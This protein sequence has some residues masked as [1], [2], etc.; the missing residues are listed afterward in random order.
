MWL[1]TTNLTLVLQFPEVSMVTIILTTSGCHK[2]E[3]IQAKPLSPLNALHIKCSISINIIIA[4]LQS[5]TNFLDVIP[6]IKKNYWLLGIME[7]KIYLVMLGS[8]TENPSLV[9]LRR[10]ILWDGFPMLSHPL[11]G[12][13]DGFNNLYSAYPV[14]GPVLSTLYLTEYSWLYEAGTI[15]FPISQRGK[16]KHGE[17]K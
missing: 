5:F 2:N 15:I 14:P 11:W 13:T 16:L 12:F 7:S 17:V 1:C 9:L 4:I 6:T 8:I 10:Y 3:L